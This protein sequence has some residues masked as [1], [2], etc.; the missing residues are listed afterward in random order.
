MFQIFLM[1]AMVGE[2]RRV[3]LLHS[4]SLVIL[5]VHGC[6]CDV[7][8]HG[9]WGPVE[10]RDDLHICGLDFAV[11]VGPISVDLV[12]DGPRLIFLMFGRRRVR[13]VRGRVLR[14]R[15][16]GVQDRRVSLDDD[17]H[18]GDLAPALCAESL[19]LLM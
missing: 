4:K 19:N 17:L 7:D 11:A 2:P 10:G 18:V 8:K 14:V 13:L 6:H 15:R 12:I 5:Y 9:K 1:G 16:E 3:H